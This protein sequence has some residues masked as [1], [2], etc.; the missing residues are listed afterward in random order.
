MYAILKVQVRGECM[1]VKTNEQKVMRDV[2]HGYIHI[3]LQVIWDLINAKEFQ[4]LRRIN[5]LGGVFQV[6][7]TAEHSRFSHSVGVYEIVRRMVYEVKDIACCL[8]E[9]EK[10]SVMIAALLHDVGHLPFSHAAEGMCSI[11]HESFS[12][13]IILGDSEVHAILDAVHPDLAQDVA[14]IIA[15]QHPNNLLNQLVSGQLDADRMDYLLRDAYVTGTS[16]GKFDL[17]RILRTIRVKDGRLVVKESGMH[18]VEDYIMAR[19]HMYWQVYFHPVARSF[20]GIL[21]LIFKR[22]RELYEKD[23]S[24]FTQ[25]SMF[26]PFLEG[27]PSIEDHFTFDEHAAYYGFSVLAHFDDPIISDLA[28][29]ILNRKL[30]EYERVQTKQEIK[31]IE[32]KLLSAGYDLEYYRILDTTSKSPYS[33]YGSQDSHNIF[34]VKKNGD[35]CELSQVSVI[36]KSLVGGDVKQEH[37]IFFPKEIS[38]E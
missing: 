4:R 17:E 31:A 37:T 8:D 1:L 23:T 26:I 27:T 21:T 15:Y 33:P 10:A 18:S 38:D 24:L 25:A 9:Y 35:V 36:V 3:D 6:Y 13:Q 32:N 20:E 12:T 7:H 22:M 19:Y 2:I 29:R 34:V 30:F 14:D 11:A 5:Q 28:K 16:Y